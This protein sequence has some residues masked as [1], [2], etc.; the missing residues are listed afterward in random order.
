MAWR[1]FKLK[2]PQ[3]HRTI[4]TKPQHLLQAD[5]VLRLL[6]Q[7]GCHLTM[8]RGQT[9]KRLGSGPIIIPTSKPFDPKTH[10]EPGTVST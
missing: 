4:W 9:N 1:S 5:S 8:G 3:P 6:V 2:L 10:I 7:V